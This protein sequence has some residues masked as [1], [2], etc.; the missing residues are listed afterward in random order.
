MW[1]QSRI[2]KPSR[3]I[4]DACWL[5][6]RVVL[7][8]SLLTEGLRGTMSCDMKS[9]AL[10]LTS[11]MVCGLP[12]NAIRAREHCPGRSWRQVKA[13]EELGWSAAK[14]QLARKYATENGSAAVTIIVDGMVLAQWGETTRRFNVHSIRKSFLNALLGIAVSEGKVSLSSTLEELGIDD[15]PPNLTREEKQARVSDLL[16]SRSGVYHPALYESDYMR[17]NRPPRGSHPPGT[18]WYYNN[19]DF[20]ALGTIFEKA[21]RS[22][23]FAEFKRRVADPLQMEDFRL[24]DTEYIPGGDSIHPAYQFRMSARD[25][26]RFGLLFL[27]RGQWQGKQI[28]SSAWIKQSTT[29]YTVTRG[30]DGGYGYLWWVAVE[31]ALFPNV[32][33]KDG[34]FAARGARGQ[35]ILVIPDLDLVIVHLVNTDDPGA[36]VSSSQFGKFL[37]LILDARQ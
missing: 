9:L 3:S 15:N 33:L 13:P 4:D 16:E 20:N 19:W 32:R 1:L 2:V 30:G 5:Q 12:G 7:G 26:A 8:G 14:L 17:I 23:I 25:M 31:G 34:A 11:M 18:F 24:D 22:T 21:T 35:A 27:R 37:R 36:A 28:V 29:A 10:I 6:K